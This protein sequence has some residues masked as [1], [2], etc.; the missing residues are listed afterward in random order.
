MKSEIR[1]CGGDHWARAEMERLRSLTGKLGLGKEKY[2]VCRFQENYVMLGPD[3]VSRAFASP[4]TREG[5]RHGR[6]MPMP[7]A[8]GGTVDTG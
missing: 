8:C 4:S 3:E 7:A 2:L 5:I 6:W 1:M